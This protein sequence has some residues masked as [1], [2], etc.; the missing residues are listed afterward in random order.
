MATLKDISV[1]TGISVSTISRVLNR[2]ETISV[3]TQTEQRIFEVAQQL[4][5]APA[6]RHGKGETRRGASRLK[7]GIAQMFEPDMVLQDP[8]YLY[9]KNELEKEC[10]EHGIETTTLFRDKRGQFQGPGE[11]TLDGIFAIGSFTPDE[12]CSFERYTPH[13]VFVDSTPDNE[14]YYAVVPN[15]H[16]GLRQALNRFLETGHRH[17]AFLGSFYTLQRTHDWLLDARLYYFRNIL[18]EEGVYDP[19]LEVDSGMTSPQAYQAL[20]Q[21]LQRWQTMPDALFISSDAMVQG[22]LRA[23]DEAKLRIPTDIS[24]IAF[25][26]TALSQNAT[27]HLSSVRVLQHELVVAALHAMTQCRENHPYPFKTVVPT[28]YVERGSV[29]PRE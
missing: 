3:S 23:L 7:M 5:Y 28:L 8:Y 13:A 25:N 12:I 24:V 11:G 1:A 16:L 2:D 27:P 10:F 6:H 17:I 29:Y 22:A 21:A 26:D 4:G 14:K 18:Q 20:G 15:F 19:A 9:M